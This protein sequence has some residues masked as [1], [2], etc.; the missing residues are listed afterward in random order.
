MNPSLAPKTGQLK[1][2]FDINQT[3]PEVCSKCGGK[4]FVQAF[5][6]R[7]VPALLSDTGKEGWLPIQVF[8]CLQDGHVNEHF[9]PEELRENIKIK[10][11][12]MS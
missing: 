11:I 8:A 2:T 7:K 1:P 3:T 10:S 6:L 5:L 9:V 12:V 4:S